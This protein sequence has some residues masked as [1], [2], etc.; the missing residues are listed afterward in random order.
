MRMVVEL[1]I[2]LLFILGYITG[3]TF[4]HII[5]ENTRKVLCCITCMS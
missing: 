5:I 3:F 2:E 1:N 4:I